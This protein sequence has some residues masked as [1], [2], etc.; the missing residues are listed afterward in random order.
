M[1]LPGQHGQPAG[2]RQSA[3][4][5]VGWQRNRSSQGRYCTREGANTGMGK[6]GVGDYC[7]RK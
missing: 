6:R 2:G 1:Q 7:C 5:A 3:P 4:S